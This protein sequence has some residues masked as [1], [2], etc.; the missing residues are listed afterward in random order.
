M[1]NFMPVLNWIVL[2]EC[3]KC[4]GYLPEQSFIENPRLEFWL[5]LTCKSC[6]GK[7]CREYHRPLAYEEAV[8]LKR[9]IAGR[10]VLSD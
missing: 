2:Y 5:G 4:L 9:V 7:D 3:N 10:W 8:E 6:M 1:R